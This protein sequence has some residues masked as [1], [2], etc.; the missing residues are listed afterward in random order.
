MFGMLSAVEFYAMNESC[1]G[2]IVDQVIKAFDD[3]DLVHQYKLK[4]LYDYENSSRNWQAHYNE[5]NIHSMAQ[6]AWKIRRFDRLYDLHSYDRAKKLLQ[7]DIKHEFYQQDLEYQK[8]M[9]D[10]VMVLSDME[11]AYGHSRLHKICD[12]AGS[13]VDLE[14]QTYEDGRKKRD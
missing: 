14:N 8:C 1:C 13:N 9:H 5:S 6:A 10:K 7:E 4:L 11:L 12:Q 2:L 3:P